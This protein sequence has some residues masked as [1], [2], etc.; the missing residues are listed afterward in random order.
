LHVEGRIHS[1]YRCRFSAVCRNA[2]A[3]QVASDTINALLKRSK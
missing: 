2:D 1:F 3:L